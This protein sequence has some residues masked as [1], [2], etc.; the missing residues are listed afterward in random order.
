MFNK[1]DTAPF[2]VALQ[3]ADF[4]ADWKKKYGKDAWALLE[5]YTGTL[6]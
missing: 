4:Y 1:V 6:A 5:K 3:K 2:R